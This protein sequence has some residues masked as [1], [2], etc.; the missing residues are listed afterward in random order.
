MLYLGSIPTTLGY[1]LFQVG[2]RSLSATLA[3]IVT[4][5]EPLTAAVLAWLL[6]HE[7]LGPAGLLGAGLLLGAM[8]IIL[9]VPKKYFQ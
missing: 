2:I 5:F 6:F 4:M 7:V 9:L 1:G 8:T 3:S